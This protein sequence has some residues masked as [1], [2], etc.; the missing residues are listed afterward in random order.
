MH[1]S[2]GLGC[3]QTFRTFMTMLAVCTSTCMCINMHVCTYAYKHMRTCCSLSALSVSIASL[4]S[5]QHMSGISGS[6]RTTKG[7]PHPRVTC[8]IDIRPH[9]VQDAC[10]R[11]KQPAQY[12]L[13]SRSRAAHTVNRISCVTIRQAAFEPWIW[14]IRENHGFGPSERESWI[15]G[16]RENHGFG[17]SERESWIWGIRENHGFGASERESWIWGIKANGKLELRH[18]CSSENR[19]QSAPPILIHV[20]KHTDMTQT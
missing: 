11:L 5:T 1:K 2:R 17:P 3:A 12:N 10:V 18:S 16:I 19:I 8:P 9:A 15:W 20:S 13:N 6:G 14:G 7:N 4:R